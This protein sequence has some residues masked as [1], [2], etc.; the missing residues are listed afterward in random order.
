[1]RA[2]HTDAIQCHDSD[3]C[4]AEVHPDSKMRARRVV[5]CHDVLSYN[6]KVMKNYEKLS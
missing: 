3:F 2:N 1:V 6:L 5:L 4:A